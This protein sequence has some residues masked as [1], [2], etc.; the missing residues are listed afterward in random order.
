M[1]KIQI[2]YFAILRDQRGLEEE[3]L[4]TNLSTAEELFVELK[5]KHGFSLDKHHMKVAIN[6]SF[7]QWSA[8]LEP[9]D[10]VTFIP[11]VAGG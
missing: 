5:E 10:H 3:T 8:R 9:G 6:D 1:K 2:T 4:E 11:P 7:A